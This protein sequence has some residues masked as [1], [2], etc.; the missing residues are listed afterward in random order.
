MG[1]IKR[2]TVSIQTNIVIFE[3]PLLSLGE[4]YEPRLLCAI[5]RTS[6]KKKLDSCW[7]FVKHLLL[8]SYDSSY[9]IYLTFVTMTLWQVDQCVH[10]FWG[11]DAQMDIFC[12]KW[13]TL[14]WQMYSH[15][16]F[17]SL[18]WTDRHFFLYCN[19][20]RKIL[21]QYNELSTCHGQIL[22]QFWSA[23]FWPIV[24][25]NESNAKTVIK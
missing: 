14:C 19:F 11:W 21:W 10:R 15:H 7:A 25:D 16:I 18:S 5:L 22:R 20:W 3:D 12:H 9:T 17:R 2:R 13:Q 8:L 23:Y 24:W 4:Q 6:T 1:T